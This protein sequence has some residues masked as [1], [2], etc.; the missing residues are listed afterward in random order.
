MRYCYD[1]SNGLNWT[2]GNPE[3]LNPPGILGRHRPR[4]FRVRSGINQSCSPEHDWERL[5][6]SS[7]WKVKGRTSEYK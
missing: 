2:V 6:P 7:M 4:L 1:H 3:Y 5:S